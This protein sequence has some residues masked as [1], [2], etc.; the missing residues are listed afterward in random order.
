MD[1]S[2]T[3]PYVPSTSGLW[4]S[5]ETDP[6]EVRSRDGGDNDVGLQSTDHLVPEGRSAGGKR[7]SSLDR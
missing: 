3:R 5:R 1:D 4:E 6:I 2:S 7:G